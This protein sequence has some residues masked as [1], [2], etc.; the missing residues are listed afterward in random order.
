[1]SIPLQ[2]ASEIEKIR[3]DAYEAGLAVGRLES[4]EAIREKYQSDQNWP[5]Q[6]FDAQDWAKSFMGR[7]GGN[8]TEISEDLML[9]WF[10][11]ALMRG[12][13]ER[14]RQRDVA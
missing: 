7:F 8:L 5:L 3:K 11:N 9:C 6:S 13:N 1:M 2:L 14:A 10:A 12:W 4:A